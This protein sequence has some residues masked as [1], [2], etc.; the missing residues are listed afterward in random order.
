MCGKEE[1]EGDCG[2]SKAMGRRQRSVDEC[3]RGGKAALVSGIGVG[4]RG[5]GEQAVV[6]GA[7]EEDEG[8]RG[9]EVRCV[10]RDGRRE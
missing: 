9:V 5:V 3:L 1:E 8:R 4:G 10:G 7:G 6:K 2:E